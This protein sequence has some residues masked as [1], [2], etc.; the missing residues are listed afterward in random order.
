MW[1]DSITIIISFFSLVFSVMSCLTTIRQYYR[2]RQFQKEEFHKIKID[3]DLLEDEFK[4]GKNVHLDFYLKRLGDIIGEIYPKSNANISVKLIRKGDKINPSNGEVVT[5]MTYPQKKIDIQTTYKIKENTDLYSIV[6]DYK[7]YFFVSDLKKYSALKTYLNEERNFIQKYNTS[8]V[9]PIQKRDD[10]KENIIGFLCI[11][12]SKKLGN[13]KKNKKLIDIVQS[14][15]SLFYDYLVDNKLNQE[16][17]T[18][19]R[20]LMLK[21]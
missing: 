17:I 15:A 1:N 10:E 13:V 21:I 7:G 2:E 8:I 19:K 4:E 16:T 3:L 5:W 18:I 20:N 14:M 6:K 11:T 12:S 9:V